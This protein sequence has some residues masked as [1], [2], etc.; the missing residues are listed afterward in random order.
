MNGNNCHQVAAAPG[1][2]GAETSN[3]T[4]VLVVAL[5]LYDSM[6]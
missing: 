6:T 2:F 4:N 5:W 1:V 3:L